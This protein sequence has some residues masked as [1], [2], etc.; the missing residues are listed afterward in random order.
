MN[1]TFFS[2]FILILLLFG[3]FLVSSSLNEKDKVNYEV[4]L[5][6]EENEKVPVK[7]EMEK[8]IF[9]S[10]NKV[11]KE[12]TEKEI[13]FETSDEIIV[14]INKNTDQSCIT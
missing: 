5:V 11:K 4:Y 14:N 8:T 10:K 13:I 3:I 6:L 2:V 1:R 12:I 7:I 9:S